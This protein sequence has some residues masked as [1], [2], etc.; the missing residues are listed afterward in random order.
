MMCI[1]AIVD[2]THVRYSLQQGLGNIAHERTTADILVEDQLWPPLDIVTVDQEWCV[3]VHACMCVCVR[4]C[5]CA[6]VRVCMRVCVRACMHVCVCVCVCVCACVC[7]CVCMC[8][9]ACVH[10]CVCVC[11]FALPDRKTESSCGWS[12]IGK[13]RTFWYKRFYCM[14]VMMRGPIVRQL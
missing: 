9:C 1:V 5:V 8:V 11:V 13:F 10:A 12:F 6:C 2:S 7:V 14:P 4:A 3:C